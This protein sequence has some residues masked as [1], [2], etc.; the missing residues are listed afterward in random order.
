MGVNEPYANCGAEIRSSFDDLVWVPFVVNCMWVFRNVTGT[1]AC[2]LRRRNQ[3]E[4]F[5]RLVLL[6]GTHSR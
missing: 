4:F 6:A 1:T 5:V 2:R 3:V